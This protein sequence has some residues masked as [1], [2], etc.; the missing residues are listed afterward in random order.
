MLPW[1]DTW[2]VKPAFDSKND[3]PQIINHTGP[4]TT[5]QII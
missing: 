4:T 5:A 2:H 3:I 1:V